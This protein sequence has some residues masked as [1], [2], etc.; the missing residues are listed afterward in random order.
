MSPEERVPLLFKAILRFWG[1][2]WRS[3]IHGPIPIPELLLG[4]SYRIEYC[5]RWAHFV[6]RTNLGCIQ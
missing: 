3:C 1:M 4:F 2:E 5:Q 6:Y